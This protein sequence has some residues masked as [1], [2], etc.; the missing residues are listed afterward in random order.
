M[1]YIKLHSIGRY[2][3]ESSEDWCLSAKQVSLLL[4]S[5]T[6]VLVGVSALF[7]K[8]CIQGVYEGCWLR[9]TRKGDTEDSYCVRITASSEKTFDESLCSLRKV[10]IIEFIFIFK[11]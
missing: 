3:S 7:W 6:N 2:F 5:H 4:A 9:S 1:G 10:E 11:F 8:K